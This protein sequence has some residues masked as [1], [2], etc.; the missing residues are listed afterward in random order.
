MA[1]LSLDKNCFLMTE[2]YELTMANGLYMSGKANE[3]A[4]LYPNSFIAGQFT[5]YS[6]VLA[7]YEST[8]PE[9]WDDLNGNISY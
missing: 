2:M 7:H 8:G 5:N 3:I 9:I 4:K 6:N 1:H